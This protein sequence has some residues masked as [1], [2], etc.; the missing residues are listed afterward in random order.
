MV[1]FAAHIFDKHILSD[2]FLQFPEI[3][4]TMINLQKNKI[5][6]DCN[7]SLHYS[8]MFDVYSCM[9]EH[10]Q[11]NTARGFSCNFPSNNIGRE[12]FAAGNISPC[13]IP[14]VGDVRSV[15]INIG[16][17]RFSRI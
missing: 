17:V 11:A 13:A 4:T 5:A 6:F 12:N 8:V 3:L 2:T 15:G 14:R 16:A 10:R 1:T 7:V 9:C